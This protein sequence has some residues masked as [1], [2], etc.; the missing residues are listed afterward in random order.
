MLSS[1]RHIF[2]DLDDTLWDF[3]RNSKEVLEQ[4][5][6]EYGLKSKLGADFHEFHS[7]YRSKN[8]EFWKRYNSGEID[9]QYLRNNRFH[10]TFKLFGH[11]DYEENL[12]ITQQ[13]LER[14]PHGKHL[15]E[16]AIEIL[17]LL[18][19]KFSLHIIT[20]GFAEV[21][22]I[23]LNGSPLRPYFK[24]I[25]I[26]ESH[27]VNKPQTA[28]FRIAEQ[29]SGAHRDECVMIGDNHDSDILGALQAGWKSIHL[30]ED[31]NSMAHLKV[32]K[33][34]ELQRLFPL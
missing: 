20:N 22:D 4:L 2:F 1:I 14:A 26:S 9:K 6:Q 32:K 5:Y 7:A 12:S 25:I 34:S 23:K 28:I 10:E 18:Q 19:K 31:E 8:T 33:L 17:E 11:N 13:Y 27:G 24:N 16:G 29:L 21:Q 3:E 15:K 30:T